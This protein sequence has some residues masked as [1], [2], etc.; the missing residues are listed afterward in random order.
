MN[1]SPE[2]LEQVGGMAHRARDEHRLALVYRGGSLPVDVPIPFPENHVV[3]N[4]EYQRGL[5]RPAESNM[6]CED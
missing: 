5:E 3:R 6:G 4:I 2:P 1:R